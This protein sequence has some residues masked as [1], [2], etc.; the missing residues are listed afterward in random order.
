MT[1]PPNKALH[2]T[3]ISLRSIAAGEL[4]RYSD[5]SRPNNAAGASPRLVIRHKA[6]YNK[7]V[8]QT[9]PSLTNLRFDTKN[10]QLTCGV[11]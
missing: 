2:L 7:S 11:R 9:C 3:A 4:G 1:I 8:E 6:P 10:M 5:A